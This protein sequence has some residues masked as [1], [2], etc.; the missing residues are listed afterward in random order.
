MRTYF[1]IYKEKTEITN[2]LDDIDI[3]VEYAVPCTDLYIVQT[4]EDD[5]NERKY[6]KINHLVQGKIKYKAL[7]FDVTIAVVILSDEPAQ[8]LHYI[9]AQDCSNRNYQLSS[10]QYQLSSDQMD[11]QV[12]NLNN[13]LACQ[14]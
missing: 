2:P 1:T 13:I 7:E 6:L 4:S 11:F 14:I 3:H 5:G 9:I 12:V 10:D 8:I